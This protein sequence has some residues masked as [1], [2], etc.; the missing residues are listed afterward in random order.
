MIDV[1]PGEW[2]SSFYGGSNYAGTSIEET[3]NCRASLVLGPDGNPYILQRTKH[4][5]GFDLHA[6]KEANRANRT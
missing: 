1:Q 3:Y 2:V 6:I 5:L 4:I